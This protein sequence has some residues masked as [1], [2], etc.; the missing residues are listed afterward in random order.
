MALAD[1][2][3]YENLGAIM[4]KGCGSPETIQNSIYAAEAYRLGRSLRG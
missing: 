4:A 3:R 1:Y 2:L